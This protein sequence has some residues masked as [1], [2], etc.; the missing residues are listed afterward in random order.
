MKK[1]C[2]QWEAWFEANLAPGD[3]KSGDMRAYLH[4]LADLDV[5]EVSGDDSWSLAGIDD[6][7]DDAALK[8]RLVERLDAL[9]RTDSGFAL[10]G[11]LGRKPEIAAAETGKPPSASKATRIRFGDKQNAAAERSSDLSNLQ[12]VKKV[13]RQLQ[14]FIEL[15][16]SWV[17]RLQGTHT[18]KEDA[19]RIFNYLL[20]KSREKSPPRQWEQLSRKRHR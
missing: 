2:A 5:F 10:S 1:N 4:H 7:L 19:K 8:D 20:S 18:R 14:S 12:I 17:S 16:Q 6:S 15:E 11:L 9:S 3:F 13:G